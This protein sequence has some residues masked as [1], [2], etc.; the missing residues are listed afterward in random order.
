MLQLGQQLGVDP[1]FDVA[2]GDVDARVPA[3]GGLGEPGADEPVR[4]AVHGHV[5]AAPLLGE[6]LGEAGDARL[7]RRVVG[8][9]GVARRPGDRGDIDDLAS[10]PRDTCRAL[11]LDRCA[12]DRLHSAQ[13]A[14]RRF[15]VHIEDVVPLLV[16]H[17]LQH[18]VPGVAGVVD[19]DVDAAEGLD[20]GSHEAVGEGGVSDAADAGH[21]AATGVGDIGSRL[22][23]DVVVE[24][25]DHDARSRGRQLQRDFATDTA[26][27]AGHERDPTGQGGHVSTATVAVPVRVTVPSARV[28]ARSRSVNV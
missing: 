19:D 1:D 11:S 8:L 9:P 10:D 20:S 24:V 2:P 25:V 18:A 27:R 28:T 26:T 3:R 12:D 15:E 7:G 21:G 16:S 22:R 14:E 5:V 6:R 23:R 17:L 13:N 4:H